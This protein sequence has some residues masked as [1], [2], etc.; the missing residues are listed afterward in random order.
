[1]CRKGWTFKITVQII[2]QQQLLFKI[3]YVVGTKCFY[4]YHL[5]DSQNNPIILPMEKTEA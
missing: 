3:Y 2:E 4:T 1:M 5:F